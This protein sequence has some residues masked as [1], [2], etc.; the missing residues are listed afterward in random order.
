MCETKAVLVLLSLVV[1][2]AASFCI[3][4]AH[5]GKTLGHH[6]GIE[7]QNPCK[8]EYKKYCLSGGEWYYLVDEDILG[9]GST[10]LYG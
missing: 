3:H 1:P 10:W 8:N 7:S 9:F 2:V 6:S 5:T 4:Q